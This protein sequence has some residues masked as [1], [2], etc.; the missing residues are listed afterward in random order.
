[1]IKP[2]DY[3]QYDTKW[4]SL[5]YA[6]DGESSTIKSAGC[7]PTALANVLA[8]IVSPYIDPIT[9]A[10][11]ARMKGY[12]VYKSGT[13][14]NY[15]AA[16]AAVYGVNVRRLN[17]SNVYGKTNNAVHNQ[18]MEQLQ[19][20]N[21]I[22]ACM[23]KGNWTSSGHFIVVYGLKD[24][25]VYINDPASTKANRAC[26]TWEL[27]KSQ[28]KYYW[29]VEV[30]DKI[31]KYGIVTDGEYPQKD[32]VRE[33]Q[34]CIKAGIDEKAGNQ[35]FS[36]TPTVSNVTNRKH[37]VVLPLQ[38]K[39]KKLGY[40]LGELDKIAGNKFKAGV[41][42]YQKEVVKASVKNQD[43]VIT[44]KASTWKKLLGIL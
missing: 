18:V 21:W 30:P 3:K 11:W 7:G 12:K 10:S 44:K 4:G 2:V 20:G 43:G 9:C 16:Q 36:K 26:N 37:A 34:M 6:V 5:S 8:A 13:S 1:M 29:V 42:Q 14:Y 41:Q 32:F 28:V 27:F 17:T 39:L 19:K 25:K 33:V 35:T 15:P 24:G 38:K 40:Y 22:I 23:G 31:K